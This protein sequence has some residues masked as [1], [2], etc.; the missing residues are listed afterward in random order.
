MELLR[1]GELS[2]SLLKCVCSIILTM[3]S[4]QACCHLGLE[5]RHKK[6]EQEDY[7]GCGCSQ[8]VWCHNGP[9]GADGFKA[10]RKSAVRSPAPR[11]EV[12]GL[13]C[14]LEHASLGMGC[15][16]YTA[17]SVDTP[18]PMSKQCMTE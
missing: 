16:G 9:G 5:I 4:S 14:S 17:N 2:R 13:L 8:D 7:T 1:F 3:Q 6:V 18:S 10:S 12:R 15:R 11:G